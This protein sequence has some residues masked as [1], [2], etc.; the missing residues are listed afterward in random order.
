MGKYN[1]GD[2]IIFNSFGR[3]K[4]MIIDNVIDMSDGNTLYEDEYGSGVFESD[5]ILGK[6]N[7]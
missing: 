5:I 3:F 6:K 7:V 4:K 2:T 1:V